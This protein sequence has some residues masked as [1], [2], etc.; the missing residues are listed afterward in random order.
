MAT[1]AINQLTADAKLTARLAAAKTPDELQQI[2][3][4]SLEN[5]HIAERDPYTG[6][7]VRTESPAAPAAA[8]VPAA[9]AAAAPKVFEKKGV[10]IA[11][12]AFDFTAD[13]AEELTRQIDGARAIAI[14]LAQDRSA[15]RTAEQDVLDKVDAERDFKLG[16]IDTATYLERTNAIS[17]YL[18][19]QGV[20][21]QK[22]SGDQYQQSWASATENFKNSAEGR[23]WPGGKKNILLISDKI[24]AMGLTNAADKAG[25][26]ATAY[27]AL[28]AAGTL[29][30]G[31]H[32][33]AEMEK[34]ALDSNATPQEI[35]HSWKQ[36]QGDLQNPDAANQEFLKAFE[37]GRRSSGLFG[38]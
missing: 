15:A 4:E 28:K 10:V 30:D 17:T 7:F 27:T 33:A 32:D 29:F 21:L 23:D 24:A 13:S 26:L 31:D 12:T 5:A 20:D 1:D 18:A 6:R 14:Q 11:G 16:I 8:V 22:I 37:N 3:H 38:R 25:A 9:A 2:L 36:A 35:L 19:S 34:L